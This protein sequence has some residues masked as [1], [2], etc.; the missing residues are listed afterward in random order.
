MKGRGAPSRAR[1]IPVAPVLGSHGFLILR[2]SFSICDMGL[3]TQGSSSFPDAVLRNHPRVLARAPTPL[4]WPLSDR[5]GGA[6]SWIPVVLAQCSPLP[7]LEREFG[8][9]C[10]RSQWLLQDPL[11][12]SVEILVLRKRSHEDL[13]RS[14]GTCLW[15]PHQGSKK[16][17]F[18]PFCQFMAQSGHRP[19]FPTYI[20]EIEGQGRGLNKVK[21]K[22]YVDLFHLLA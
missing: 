15:L 6:S 9:L 2:K 17:P 21:R 4:D 19:H 22:P 1:N 12:P 16:T 18:L 11:A 14:F 3:V 20:P 13:V 7:C 5:V 8:I 10:R